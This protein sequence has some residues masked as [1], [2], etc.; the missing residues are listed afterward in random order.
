[1]SGFRALGGA[2]AALAGRGP[3]GKGRDA[4]GQVQAEPTEPE[5]RSAIGWARRLR[6]ING[7][8]IERRAACGGTLRSIACLED[9]AV[10]ETI[11]GNL[12]RIGALRG[13]SLSASASGAASAHGPRPRAPPPTSPPARSPQLGIDEHPEGIEGA[14]R[15]P[16]PRPVPGFEELS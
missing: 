16:G 3:G 15:R 6:R 5:R 8:D 12:R 11:L 1:M 10:I 4:N 2:C 9:R 14:E 7:R 13:T